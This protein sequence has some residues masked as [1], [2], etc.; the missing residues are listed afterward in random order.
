MS[1][2]P[3]LVCFDWD[4][5]LIDSFDNIVEAIQ[6]AAE[7]LNL[8][9]ATDAK[10][11]RNIG[12]SFEQL[13]HDCYGTHID[14]GVFKRVFHHAYHQLKVAPLFPNVER[15]LSA[16]KNADI[17]IAIVTNKSRYSLEIELDKHGLSAKFDSIWVAEDFAPKPSPI[18]LRHASSSHQVDAHETWMVGDALP[19]LYAGYR[20]GCGRILLVEKQP[21]PETIQQ[22]EIMHDVSEILK[23]LKKQLYI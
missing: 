1:G 14:V 3:K 9:K 20:A 18:M 2:Q 10:I 22:C 6:I 19:D 7:Q 23:T 8:P 13:I 16:L 21:V 15:L 11:K 5:T 4:G 12:V 17:K